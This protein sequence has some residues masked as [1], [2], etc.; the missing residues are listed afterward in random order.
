MTRLWH[1]RDF[2]HKIVIAIVQRSMAIWHTN[3]IRHEENR[4][5]HGETKAKP[6]DHKAK[7][8]P[9]IGATQWPHVPD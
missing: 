5:N 1:F 8:P 9:F 7:R 2:D 4:D 3:C 6:F